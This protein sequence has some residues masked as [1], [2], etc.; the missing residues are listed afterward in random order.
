M[1]SRGRLRLPLVAASVYCVLLATLAQAQSQ[2]MTV[3][4]IAPTR[5]WNGQPVSPVYEGFDINP[6][7]SYNMWFGYMNRNYEED[8]DVPVGPDNRFEPA[9]PDAGSRRIST[10]AATRTSSGSWCRRISADQTLHWTLTAHG[11]TRQVSAR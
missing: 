11:K 4:A 8:I 7:G 1:L 2:P 9:G 3:G 5:H 10:R 6:D